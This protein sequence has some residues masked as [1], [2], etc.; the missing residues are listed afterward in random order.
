MLLIFYFHQ[1]R[2]EKGR[3]FEVRIVAL[4]NGTTCF[5]FLTYI[6]WKQLRPHSRFLWRFS[7]SAPQNLRYPN[8]LV[9]KPQNQNKA[10]NQTNPSP[11]HT[12]QTPGLWQAPGALTLWLG[13]ES[14]VF[15]HQTL[16][17]CE[18]RYQRT[19]LPRRSY[20][21]QMTPCLAHHKPWIKHSQSHQRIYCRSSYR[22]HRE[23]PWE[24]LDALPCKYTLAR[25]KVTCIGLIRG[26]QLSLRILILWPKYFS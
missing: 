11:N 2:H 1:K 9:A 7:G 16:F 18:E 23:N 5:S 13:A 12:K 21:P 3:T 14:L 10:T 8:I 4:I 25:F 24:K 6:Q 17:I 20:G 15:L 26:M 19:E 22:K